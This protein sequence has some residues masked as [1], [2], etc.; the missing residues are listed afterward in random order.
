MFCNNCGKEITED[1]KFCTYCGQ[2]NSKLIIQEN[3]E[4]DIIQITE[5]FAINE[6]R[7]KVKINGQLIDF[8]EIT[9]ARVIENVANVGGNITTRIRD[10][11]TIDYSSGFRNRTRS[12]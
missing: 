1:A 4:E 6:K 8:S 7:Q 5:N 2:A 3:R 12:F 11:K 9:G 10:R